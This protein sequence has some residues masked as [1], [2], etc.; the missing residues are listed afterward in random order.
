MDP[1]AFHKARSVGRPPKLTAKVQADIV[2]AIRAGNYV[3]TAAAFAGITKKT[4]YE[5]VKKGARREGRKYIEFLNAVRRADAEAELRDVATIE[6]AS[7]AS[8]QAAAW[9]LE[10]KHSKK[11]GRK[12]FLAA[13]VISQSKRSLKIYHSNLTP[14]QL[15]ALDNVEVF[16]GNGGVVTRELPPPGVD[17]PPKPSEG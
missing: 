4:L 5:W 7:R 6:G 1:K 11:W 12:D 14:E 9:R 15:E 3:E 16:D 8:W 13:N 17:A 2:T 10:R